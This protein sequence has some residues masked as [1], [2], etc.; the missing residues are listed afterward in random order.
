MWLVLCGSIN[1]CVVV[2]HVTGKQFV[3]NIMFNYYDRSADGLLTRDELRDVEARDEL[4]QLSLH[5]RL[6]DMTSFDDHNGDGNVTLHEFQEAFGEFEAKVVS[7][8]WTLVELSGWFWRFGNLADFYDTRLSRQNDVAS[9]AN[10]GAMTTVL[11]PT[12]SIEVWRKLQCYI[13]S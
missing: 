8:M 2:G 5:C 4:S 13:D 6:V 9:I 10:R 1:D 7:L 12:S 3:V 11:K